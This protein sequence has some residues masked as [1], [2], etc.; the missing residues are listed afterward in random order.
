MEFV[1]VRSNT[2]ARNNSLG[3]GVRSAAMKGGIAAL[4]LALLA[5]C[6]VQPM[7]LDPKVTEQTVEQD[8][9]RMYADQEPLSGPLTLHEAMARAIKYN[10]DSRLRVMEHALQ[11]RQLDVS[12]YDMLPKVTADAGYE[13]RSNQ[14]A[15]SSQNVATG[16]Q[17]LAPSTSSERDRN[18]ASLKTVWNILDFGVSYVSAQQQAD[19][20]LIAYERRRKVIHNIIQDVRAA[21]WRAVAAERLLKRVDPLMERVERARRDSKRIEALRLRSPIQ[22]LSYQRTLLETLQQLEAQRRELMLART[23]LAALINLP[24]D[25]DFELA[26]PEESRPIPELDMPMDEM[27]ML[28]LSNRPELREVHYQARIDAAETRKAM[29]RMLPGLEFDAGLNYDSNDFLVNNQWADYGARI[30][31]NLFNVFT[32]QSRIAGG[33]G[34]RAGDEVA[35][36]GVEHGGADP[37]LCRAGELCRVGSPVPDGPRDGGDQPAYCRAASC[38][39]ADAAG[40]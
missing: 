12:N 32:G 36:D 23:E 19:R 31:W 37:A 8:L 25:Q 33:G 18:V 17:S 26:M 16:Q 1:A 21:Y 11:Q 7:P 24:L 6:A 27:E 28:A 2:A 39:G 5:G 29:L 15:S 13:S 30:S 14:S 20:A 22:A 4:T 38:R 40:W 9:S 34:D 35:A 3:K 10:L